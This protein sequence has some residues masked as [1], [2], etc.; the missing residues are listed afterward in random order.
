M[1]KALLLLLLLGG[2]AGTVDVRATNALAIACDTYA[3]VLDQLTP[4]KAAGKLSA[5]NIARVDTSNGYVKPL[6]GSGS[7][8]DPATAINTVQQAIQLIVVLKG[9]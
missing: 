1:R 5:A 7:V 6:C 4:M 9:T 2:C 3:T 8:V